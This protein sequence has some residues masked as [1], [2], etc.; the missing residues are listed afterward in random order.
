MTASGSNRERS[1]S[2]ATLD[3]EL[4]AATFAR[5]Q[6]FQARFGARIPRAELS[7]GVTFHGERTPIWNYQKGIFKPAVLGRDGA[8]LSI[9]TSA[10]SPYEDEHD[11]DAGHFIYK[12]RGTDP[13]HADNAALRRAMV[14]RRPLIYFV[15]VDAGVYDGGLPPNPGGGRDNGTM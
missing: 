2:D 1:L 4:R 11:P 12:Y 3:A 10:D 9:Q 13:K 7:A 8:A 15:A 6:Q 14:D 5:V